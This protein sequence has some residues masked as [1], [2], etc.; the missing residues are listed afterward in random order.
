MRTQEVTLRLV[1]EMRRPVVAG[2][3]NEK[4]SKSKSSYHVFRHPK[5][6][7]FY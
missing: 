4:S 7:K 2:M 5:F 6:L 1:I 3:W